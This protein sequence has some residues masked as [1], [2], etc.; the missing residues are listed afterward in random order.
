MALHPLLLLLTTVVSFTQSTELFT[1]HCQQLT[2][3]RSDPIVMP[4]EAS[5]HVHN[6]VG[7]TAFYRNESATDAVKSTATTCDK[8]LDHSNYWVPA[9]YHQNHNGTFSLVP[10]DEDSMV[11]GL[12]Q[13]V[14][15]V[16]TNHGL[17]RILLP[18]LL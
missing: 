10:V 6:V 7:G 5:G 1:V 16:L 9:L 3:Q 14:H 8:L 4:G 13:H 17:D 2:V 18:R 12:S 11:S 15:E